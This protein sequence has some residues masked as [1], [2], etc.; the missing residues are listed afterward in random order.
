MKSTGWYFFLGT[1]LAACNGAPS[2]DKQQSSDSATRPAYSCAAPKTTDKDWYSSGKKAPL[3]EGMEGIDFRIST[4]NKDVQRYFNQGLM[5]AYGFNHAEAARSFYEATRLDSTCAMAYWGFAYVLGPNYNAGMEEDN[6]E[7]AYDAASKAAAL[8]GNASDKEKAL[9]KALTSRY[10]K[11]A[12]A[13]RRALDIAYAAAMKKVYEQYSSDPDIGALYA[14]AQMDLH[15]WDLYD[16][17]TKSPKSW[18]P[19]L[20]AVLEHLMTINP[21]HPGAHHF[22]IHAVEASAKPEQGLASAKLLETMVPGSG[23]LVHMPSHIYILTGNYH[24]GSLTNLAAIKADSN[25]LTACHAQG[26]YPLAYYPHNYHFLAATATL[27]GNSTL[28]W[29][30]AVKMQKDADSGIMRMPGWGTLQHYYTMPYYIAVKFAMWDTILSLPSPQADLVYPRAIWHFA[31]GL[32]YLGK[33]EL[34]SAQSELSKLSALAADS[35]LQKLTVWNIN[36]TA[37][38][39]YIANK[40][41]AAEIASKQRQWQQAITLLEAAIKQEDNLNYNEPPDWLFSVRHHLGAVLLKAGKYSEAEKVY[42]RDLQT[43]RSNGWAL[44]GLYNALVQQKKD[45]QAVQAKAQFDKAWQYAD[46]K[47]SSSSSL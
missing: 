42:L 19:A 16:K 23:H 14:E 44:I 22:Y 27:E 47:I 1:L 43:W 9:I 37:D 17:Q 34:S 32:A 38:L 39:A 4:G 31:R 25:Y 21:R 36:T 40:V 5:L 12:P 30:A 6:F 41:L 46:V 7:R 26:A 10:A 29:M 3:L 28:A 35:S 15:P 20:L 24:E 18:T 45:G 13:D 8:S 11:P 2:S 33:N